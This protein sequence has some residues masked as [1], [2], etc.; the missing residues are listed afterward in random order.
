[1][2]YYAEVPVDLLAKN[3]WWNEKQDVTIL[4]DLFSRCLAWLVLRALSVTLFSEARTATEHAN[5]SRQVC[6]VIYHLNATGGNKKVTLV[7]THEEELFQSL[8]GL[9]RRRP[10]CNLTFP[11]EKWFFPVSVHASSRTF[12]AVFT[13]PA[14][15]RAL[16]IEKLGYKNALIR[17]ENPATR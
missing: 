12:A 5:Q 2:Q 1:M 4:H 13:S 6:N 9:N 7:T 3:S 16:N 15:A 10:T 8:L 14:T 11:R 17:K